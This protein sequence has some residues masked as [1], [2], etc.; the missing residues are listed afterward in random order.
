MI[1]LKSSMDTPAEKPAGKCLTFVLDTEYCGIA[2]PRMR[3]IIRQTSVTTIPQMPDCIMG[4][5][6]N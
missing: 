4:V 6:N 3:E 2:V 5:I 1:T